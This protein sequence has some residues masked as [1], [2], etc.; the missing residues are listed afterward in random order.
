MGTF[1]NLGLKKEII[2]VLS[3]LRFNESLDVQDKVIPLAMK[4][5]NIVFTSKTL[6]LR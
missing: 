6:D 1:T 4:R 5:K 2:K 3:K